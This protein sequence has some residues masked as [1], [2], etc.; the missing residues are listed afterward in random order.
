MSKQKNPRKRT[1]YEAMA[2]SADPLVRDIYSEI[3]DRDLDEIAEAINEVY[4]GSEEWEDERSFEEPKATSKLSKDEAV[5]ATTL[6][7]QIVDWANYAKAY[8]DYGNPPWEQYTQYDH[9]YYGEKYG[10]KIQKLLE[11]ICSEAKERGYECTSPIDMSDDTY[12]WAVAVSPPGAE[13]EDSVDVSVEIA[14]SEAYDGTPG[15]LNFS[16][17]VVSY[18]G[19]MLGGLTPYNYT[20]EVWV[21][22]SDPDAVEER[23]RLFDNGANENEVLYH[24]DQFYE[25]REDNPGTRKLKNK[26]LR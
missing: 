1:P 3:D 25:N 16:M 10:P 17:N 9:D 11:I 19:E 13:T 5:D 4:F 7:S 12:R 21:S 2:W 14:T 26:L 15:G 8:G 20:D 22:M 23:W 18:E 24:I 6:A